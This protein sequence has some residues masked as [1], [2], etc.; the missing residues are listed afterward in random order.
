MPSSSGMAVSVSES[1]RSWSAGLPSRAVTCH[2]WCKALSVMP[3]KSHSAR[4]KGFGRTA[5]AMA[6][7][8]RRRAI[9]ISYFHLPVPTGG[10][11]CCVLKR[12]SDS[13]VRSS[14]RCPN[15]RAIVNTLL[16]QL[17]NFISVI[18]EFAIKCRLS[19]S[20]RCNGGGHTHI[21]GRIA[22]GESS[23]G[24]NISQPGLRSSETPGFRRSARVCQFRA[25]DHGVNARV[26]PPRGFGGAAGFCV[27][28]LWVQRGTAATALAASHPLLPSLF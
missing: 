12:S 26:V 25:A 11:V 13:Q 6:A 2:Q 7:L 17:H 1:S 19:A 9:W 5:R 24:E 22:S 16:P 3:A 4:A 28:Q 15:E 14:V 20:C 10:N 18:Q 8:Q 27:F 21:Q 23:G